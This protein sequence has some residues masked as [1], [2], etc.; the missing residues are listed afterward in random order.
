MVERNRAIIVDVQ[1]LASFGQRSLGESSRSGRSDDTA[2]ASTR[3]WHELRPA[4]YAERQNE[5]H[6]EAVYVV[7]EW[8]EERRLSKKGK[9]RNLV[10]QVRG[11]EDDVVS[12][13][14]TPYGAM[15]MVNRG[16]TAETERFMY[17]YSYSPGSS[18]SHSTL[19]YAGIVQFACPR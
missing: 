3:L 2:V 19:L 18:A 12:C 1:P 7:L 4:S 13:S 11:N 15:L 5:E 10:V 9:A 8:A 6:Y 14:L 16:T 17:H